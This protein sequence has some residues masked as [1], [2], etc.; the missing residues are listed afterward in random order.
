MRERIGDVSDRSS[1][2]MNKAGFSDTIGAE[3]D[4]FG[5]GSA[6]GNAQPHFIGLCESFFIAEGQ[7]TTRSIKNEIK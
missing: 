6:Q 5:A 7:V 4:Y 1:V 2:G 3:D